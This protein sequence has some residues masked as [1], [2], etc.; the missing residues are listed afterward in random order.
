VKAIQITELI[1]VVD[2]AGK[3][4]YTFERKPDP[5]FY[6]VFDEQATAAHIEIWR[7]IQEDQRLRNQEEA[8]R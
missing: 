5:R 2:D 7:A 8:G 1:H 6:Y 3:I 4:V